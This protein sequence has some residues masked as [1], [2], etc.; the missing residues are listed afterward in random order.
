MEA[1][2]VVLAQPAFPVFSVAK[3]MSS[4]LFENSGILR[5]HTHAACRALRK[6][7]RAGARTFFCFSKELSA[8]DQLMCAG[9]CCLG[10][11]CQSFVNPTRWHRLRTAFG[12]LPALFLFLLLGN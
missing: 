12:E 6:Q 11:S 5:A 3:P 9:I 10:L 1:S 8:G 4:P 2:E 7:W